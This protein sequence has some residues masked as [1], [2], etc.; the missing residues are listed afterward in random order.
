[1]NF[2]D[3]KATTK[4]KWKSPSSRRPA[5]E[6]KDKAP[7]GE[8]PKEDNAPGLIH[9]RPA[10]SLYEW[11]VARAL[12]ALGWKF[13]YQVPVKGGREVRGGQVLDFLVYTVPLDTAVIVNG[14]YWHQTDEEYKINELMS[15][16]AREGKSVNTEPVVLWQKEAAT[17]EAAY[18]FLNMKIGKG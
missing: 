15:A 1:M 5:T 12:G 16:L 3:L 2:A 7:M 10:G 11:N 18:S 14:D 6:A 17:Y 9:G 4:L 13:A 8:L